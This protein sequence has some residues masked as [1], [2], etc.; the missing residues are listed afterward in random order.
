M[1][2]DQALALE[3]PKH[4]DGAITQQQTI[5]SHAIDREKGPV[6]IT[7]D[8]DK[9]ALGQDV[10]HALL[11]F[12]KVHDGESLSKKR[13]SLEMPVSLLNTVDPSRP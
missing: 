4:L 13:T 5:P 1:G 11:V 6:I 12:G 10:Q 2:A 7:H 3:G 8:L 9:P